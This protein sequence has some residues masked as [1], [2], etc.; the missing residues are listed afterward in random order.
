VNLSDQR[1]K[2]VKLTKMQ[3]IGADLK[4][5]LLIG[6]K[7][8]D[9]FFTG[10]LFPIVDGEELE[11]DIEINEDNILDDNKEEATTV[12]K[13][14]RYIPPSSAGFSFFIT[15]NNIILRVFYNAVQY[16]LVGE[17][18]SLNQKFIKQSWKK[19]YLADDGKEVIFTLNGMKQYKIFDGKAKIDAL[20]RPYNNGH[21]VT[22]T[23]S[24][25]T[26]IDA[27][28]SGKIFNREQ[29]ENTLF[30][31]EFKCIIE[32]GNINIYPSKNKA[33]LSDEEK[34]IELRYK[35]LHIYAV[36][37]G[38]AVNW[39]KNKQNKMEIWTDFMPTVEVPQVTADTGGKSDKVL[40]FNFLKNCDNN[41]AIIQELH[42]FILT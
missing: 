34:E 25:D 13:D 19:N 7:P 39:A 40:E 1:D 6:Q 10:F 36:G 3:L 24:N 2:F 21:I 8:L 37:H 31:V 41:D 16:S 32:K 22:I 30:E 26:K 42:N 23:M 11:G 14:K 18:D 9:R 27:T 5:K 15:G 4:D 38:T 17:R 29:N 35:D 28:K 20:W 12:K 33:L